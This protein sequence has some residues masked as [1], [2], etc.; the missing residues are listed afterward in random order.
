VA[1]LSFFTLIDE[2][3]EAGKGSYGIPQV[4]LYV[5]LTVPRAAYELFPI[6]AVIGS[7]VVLGIMAQ[8]SE[9]DVI[10]TS[11]VSRFGLAM[12][13]ARCGL[14]LVLISVVLGEFI[15]PASEEKAQ[16][17]RSVAMTRQ[18]TL[19]TKHGLWSRNGNRFIN[20]K[21]V[22]SG[23]RMQDVYIYEFDNDDRLRSSVFAKRAEYRDGHW[24]MHD[25][26]QSLIDDQGVR[27]RDI[28]LATWNSLL[29]P[30][31]INV[32]IVKPQSLS[33][34]ELAGYIRYL[35]HNAQNTQIYEQA[36]WSKLIRPFSI[37]AM[38]M[39][40]VVLVRGHSRY[41]AIGQ[42]VFIGALAGIIF[43]LCNE[44]SAHIGVV[45]GISPA[46]S[47]TAPTLLLGLTLAF[48]LRE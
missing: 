35:R 20:I 17:M 10:R 1:L 38:I 15:A 48:M 14:V 13:L 7:M 24:I 44:V 39:L 33:I 6:A 41:S 3:G 21:K 42:R 43:H 8:N 28:K 30:D 45:Y 46:V 32:V 26:E 5:I 19:K 34:W 11:G 27:R 16:H 22:L 12:L 4:L 18:I 23:N 37:L 2:L 9:L 40:A 29:D 36:L 25:I 31:M 47:V